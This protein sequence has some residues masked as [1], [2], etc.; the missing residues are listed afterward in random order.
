MIYT[1]T[2]TQKYMISMMYMRKIQKS[3]ISKIHTPK[4]TNSTISMIYTQKSQ[5]SAISEI[6]LYAA[7]S[8]VGVSCVVLYWYVCWRAF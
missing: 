3:K 2:K 8:I 4:Y 5:P 1:Q 7:I 6:Y